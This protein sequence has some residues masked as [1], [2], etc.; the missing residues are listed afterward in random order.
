MCAINEEFDL[1]SY[2]TSSHLHDANKNNVVW[3]FKD[4]PSG[5][6]ISQFV[7]GKPTMY[8]Y[9]T[10]IRVAGIHALK[11]PSIGRVHANEACEWYRTSCRGSA[12]ALGI[13]GT[14]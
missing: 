11:D 5:E 6:S 7:D 10:V 13:N 4:E 8:S 9:Q 12:S 14:S 2:P 1:A 3:N